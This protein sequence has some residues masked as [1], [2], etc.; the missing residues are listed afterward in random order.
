MKR[1][2]FIALLLLCVWTLSSCSKDDDTLVVDEEWK[3]ENEE[4]FQAQILAPDFSKLNSQSNAGFI[5]YKVLK[6]GES[7][8]QI[9]YTSTVKLYYKGSLID[10][11]V[12][13]DHSFENSSG[14]TYAVSSLVDGFQTALQNMHPGDRWI[15][16]IPQQLGYGAAGKSSSVGVSILPYT[17]LIFD[18]EVVEVEQ[19]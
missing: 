6:T 9:Y 7:K 13:D 10:D 1:Y 15:V 2:G 19:E 12:F 14:A 4:A 8:E 11:T 16:W 5:L 3:I 17:T 18:I